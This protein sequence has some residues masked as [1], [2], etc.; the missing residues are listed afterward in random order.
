M[1]V[2]QLNAKVCSVKSCKSCVQEVSKEIEVK[3]KLV[4]SESPAVEWDTRR[5]IPEAAIPN[6]LSAHPADRSSLR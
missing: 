5:S 4:E 2:K 1:V 6:D 3:P